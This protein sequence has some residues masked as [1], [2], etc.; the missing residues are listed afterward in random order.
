MSNFDCLPSG[1]RGTPGR[2]GIPVE[3]IHLSA[4]LRTTHMSLG[5]KYL[6]RMR[7]HSKVPR[8]YPAEPQ[9]LDQGIVY[10]PLATSD[11]P[12]PLAIAIA[13]SVVFLLTVIGPEYNVE[14]VV[15]QVPSVV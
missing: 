10:A 2:L 13:F 6:S 5:S 3:I 7:C 1:A 4:F 9:S 15:G 12:Y 11:S 14:L 8:L